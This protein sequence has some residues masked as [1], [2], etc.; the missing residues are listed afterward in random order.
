MIIVWTF[1]P[2]ADCQTP[3]PQPH[4]GA[5]AIYGNQLA[6]HS[7]PNTLPTQRLLSS[8]AFPLYGSRLTSVFV[9]LMRAASRPGGDFLWAPRNTTDTGRQSCHRGASREEA[10]IPV[11]PLS[12]QPPWSC[13]WRR[14]MRFD[15]RA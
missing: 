12:P 6:R 11:S 7:P 9:S 8:E 13:G 5:R 14:A 10:S 3:C 1:T 15:A 4:S 2:A